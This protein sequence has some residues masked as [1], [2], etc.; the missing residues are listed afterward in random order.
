[1]VQ[2]ARFSSKALA[3]PRNSSVFLSDSR[4]C[5][6]NGAF[7]CLKKKIA[8]EQVLCVLQT[9]ALVGHYNLQMHL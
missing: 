4:M 1:M 9:N 3:F 2:L 6:H 8:W 7:V 5:V